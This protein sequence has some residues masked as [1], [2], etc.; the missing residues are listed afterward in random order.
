MLVVFVHDPLEAELPD[1]GRLVAG[2][3]ELQLAFDS[4]DETLRRRFAE[5]FSERLDAARKTLQQR[6][7]PVLSVHTGLP[8]AEQVRG[9]LGR[10][11]RAGRARV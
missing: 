3:G 5:D 6:A 1:L 8:V 9:L 2:D 7:I 10:R 4:D 11:P